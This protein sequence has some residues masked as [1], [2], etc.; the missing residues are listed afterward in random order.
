MLSSY[1]SFF[2]EGKHQFGLAQFALRTAKG[3]DRWILLVFLAFTL[4]LLHRS[5]DMTLKEAARLTLYALFPEVRLNH[6]L[7]QLQKEQEFLRQHGYSLS[8]TRCN[9]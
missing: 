6:L 8:Y 3:L 9:L 4:T 1:E 2:K 7:S 5:E